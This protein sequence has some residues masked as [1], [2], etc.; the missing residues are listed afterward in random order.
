MKRLTGKKMQED[1][2][3]KVKIK[4]DGQK[5]VNINDKLISDCSIFSRILRGSYSFT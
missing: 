3:Q 4:E 1:E 5:K 2:Q